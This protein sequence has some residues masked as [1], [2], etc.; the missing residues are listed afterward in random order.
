MTDLSYP[1]K[2]R[3]GI[4]PNKDLSY[5]KLLNNDVK[6]GENAEDILHKRIEEFFKCSLTKTQRYDI[7]DYISLYNKMFFE[8][9]SRKNKKLQYPTTMIGFNKII[10][11]KQ[12][13]SEGY[14]VILLFNFTDKLCY[15][16]LTNE[17]INEELVRI[18]G[19]N[20][21]GRAE[22]KKHYFIPVKDLID[23]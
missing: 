2:V 15:Y 18:A 5:N 13:I 21:R 3:S 8:L 22:Y 6:F 1:H 4:S 10:F 23:F 7:F 16:E 11:G 17:N 14:R 12:K 9:K 19:R 20:D